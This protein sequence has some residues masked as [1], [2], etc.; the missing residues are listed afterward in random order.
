MPAELKR[1][2]SHRHNKN[3]SHDAICAVCYMTVACRD[4]EAE[5]ASLEKAHVCDPT[6]LFELRRNAVED[7][8]NNQ[9]D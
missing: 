3:G 5:L 9:C 1:Q 7:K 8:K 2:F 6:R 4:A